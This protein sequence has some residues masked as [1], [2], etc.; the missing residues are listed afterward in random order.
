MGFTGSPLYD[1]ENSVII[2]RVSVSE[3]DNFSMGHKDILVPHYEALALPRAF[4]NFT[5]ELVFAFFGVGHFIIQQEL[6]L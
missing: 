6:F 3:T 5:F 1:M 2:L 4:G